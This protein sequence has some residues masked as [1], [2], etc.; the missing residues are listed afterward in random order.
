[1]ASELFDGPVQFLDLREILNA[2]NGKALY[3]VIGRV[4]CKCHQNADVASGDESGG[5]HASGEVPRGC[6]QF[7]E[8][9]LA[10]LEEVRRLQQ[11]VAEIVMPLYELLVMLKRKI[12]RIKITRCSFNLPCLLSR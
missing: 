1:M 9:H 10:E 5:L 7:C 2:V 12:K 11:Q 3:F 8:H 6:Y 4:E